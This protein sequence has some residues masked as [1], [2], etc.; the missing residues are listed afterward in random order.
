MC[1]VLSLF[2]GPHKS[3]AVHYLSLLPWE[4]VSGNIFSCM[5]SKKEC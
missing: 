1:T 2:H 3:D 5:V 4:L